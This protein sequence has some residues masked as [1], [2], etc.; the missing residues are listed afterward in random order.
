[1][2]S[3]CAAQSGEHGIGLLKQPYLE[4]MVGT[5]ENELMKS[6]KNVFDAAG[7]LNPGRG[8]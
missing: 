3:G 7:I 5:T 4:K 2:S 1:V 8:L 6:I